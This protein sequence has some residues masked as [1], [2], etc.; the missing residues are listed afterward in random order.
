MGLFPVS[1]L[2]CI[3]RAYMEYF[4]T[5]TAAA[6]V[7]VRW[8]GEIKKR[9]PW[10]HQIA[11][12]MCCMYKHFSMSKAPQMLQWLHCNLCI[13]D[14]ERDLWRGALQVCWCHRFLAQSSPHCE[15]EYKQAVVQQWLSLLLFTWNAKSVLCMSSY[16]SWND[17]SCAGPLFCAELYCINFPSSLVPEYFNN[18][19]FSTGQN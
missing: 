5:L 4:S 8:Y 1:P 19:V 15:T 2:W 11:A 13:R 16:K 18:N 6:F 10:L 9:R 3:V 12:E 17:K 7:S 14:R